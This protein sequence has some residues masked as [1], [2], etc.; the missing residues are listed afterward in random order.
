MTR[1][2]TVSIGFSVADMGMVLYRVINVCTTR[3]IQFTIFDGAVLRFCQALVPR[4]TTGYLRADQQARI[5]TRD[6]MLKA[7]CK[8]RH[9]ALVI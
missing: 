5:P 2:S 3:E 9:L 4:F 1:L 6:V 8:C 7:N